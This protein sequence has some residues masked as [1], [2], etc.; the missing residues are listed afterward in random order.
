MV[1]LSVL[2]RI[3]QYSMPYKDNEAISMP[4][5]SV[6]RLTVKL[7]I[8][9]TGLFLEMSFSYIV[10]DNTFFS[11][12]DIL[13]KHGNNL[14]FYFYEYLLAYTNNPWHMTNKTCEH[15]KLFRR[16][17]HTNCFYMKVEEI[18]LKYESTWLMA[19]EIAPGVIWHNLTKRTHTM[20]L[21]FHEVKND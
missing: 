18:G 15:E 10:V 4:N 17:H 12:E 9:F 2:S 7:S 6:S 3:V 20:I 5:S 19:I 13:Q 1:T 11:L 21:M 16:I 14:L 8:A